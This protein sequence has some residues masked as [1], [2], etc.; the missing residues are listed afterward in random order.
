[1]R[2]ALKINM[3][4]RIPKAQ[5]EYKISSMVSQVILPHVSS[6]YS[7]QSSPQG[8]CL[9]I[10]YLIKANKLLH[11]DSAWHLSLPLECPDITRASGT[12]A[13]AF[14]WGMETF[15]TLALG[16]KEAPTMETVENPRCYRHEQ[17][18]ITDLQQAVSRKRRSS[19]RRRKA[20]RRLATARARSARR[21]LDW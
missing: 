3:L 19:N 15:A 20:A 1:M 8:I 4:Q 2:W 12:G 13:V 18:R 6:A 21:R 14:D 9:H 17:Q 16:E 5:E 10:C 11:R 7:C